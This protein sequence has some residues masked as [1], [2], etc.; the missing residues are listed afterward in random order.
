MDKVKAAIFKTIEYNP[1]PVQ[2][3][4]HESEHR[5]KFLGAGSRFGKSLCGS[6]DVLTDILKE[7]T[8]GWI[9]GPSYDQPSK[10]FRYI[11]DA[12]IN[13]LGFKPKRELNVSFTTPG[14]QSLLFPWGSE[15]LTKSEQ[16]LDSLLGEEVDWMIL[17]EGSRLKEETYDNYLRARLGS[18]NGRVIIPTTPHGYNWLY[19]RFYLPFVEG[20]KD[21]WARIGVSVIENPYF[22]KE[23][24]DRAKKEL[25]EDV[26]AEQYDGEF[27]AWSGLIY[28][29][30]SRQ[31]NVIDPFGIPTHWPVYCAID[32]HPSTPVGILWLTV[33]EYG[34]WYVCHE[35]FHPDLTIPEVA[36]RLIQIE[37]KCPVTR[38]LI[39]PNAKLIDKLRGQT[40][41]VQMQFRREGIPCIEANNKFEGAWFKISEMLTPKPVF[42]D[43]ENKKPK[44]L[45]FKDCKKTI[46]E[47]EGYTWENEKSGKAHLMDCLKYIANDNPQRALKEEE[48]EEAKRRESERMGKMN[49]RTGY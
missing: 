39:D 23:E 8:R 18:R 21:Y 48:E 10:E 27:V 26:F 11:H 42:G 9:V 38:Y 6:R 14:P 44:L 46:E 41:S 5:F 34:T 47:F 2:I 16:N 31:R 7:G 1:S 37:K 17:S 36:K 24:Y 45:I 25:P 13:K 3:E 20:D 22:P 32:P 30:F 15:V 35:M 4:F 28:K 43:E 29:R 49:P 40:I 33:D 12:L 19:K